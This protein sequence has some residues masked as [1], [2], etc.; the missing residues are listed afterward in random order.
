MKAEGGSTSTDNVYSS[1]VLLWNPQR[2]ICLNDP[3]SLESIYRLRVYSWS[4]LQSIKKIVI[5]RKHGLSKHYLSACMKHIFTFSFFFFLLFFHATL[6][7]MH[8]RTHMHTHKIMQTNWALLFQHT[9]WWGELG[10]IGQ[11]KLNDKP[12][13]LCCNRWI[14]TWNLLLIYCRN[15]F[16][17]LWFVLWG[18]VQIFSLV[19]RH[20]NYTYICMLLSGSKFQ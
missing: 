3:H 8:A 4:F 9:W 10:N 2:T 16:K 15:S 5:D 6:S 20:N 12:M 11:L 13:Q 7:P 18:R 14:C 1:T 19:W 17:Q